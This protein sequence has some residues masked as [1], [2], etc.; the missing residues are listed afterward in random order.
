MKP[1]IILDRD[2]VINEDSENYIRCPEEWKAIPGSLEAIAE[3][4]GAGYSIVVATNQ[5]GVAKKVFSME[6][7]E[8]IHQKMQDN[9]AAKGGKI[10]RIFFCPHHP[11]ER[12]GCRKPEPG[13]LLDACTAFDVKPSGAI[14]LG[15]S[16]RDIQAALKA[17]CKAVLVLTG[18]GRKT[19]ADLDA[20]TSA[21]V[22]VFD[23]LARFAS[24][25][26]QQDGRLEVTG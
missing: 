9:V 17:G 21:Q 12:C 22:V 26:L 15:D 10:S 8:A 4:S 20:Q 2:G 25:L 24:T 19:L 16:L 18:N 6:V 14:F 1:L 3:L 5:A 11:D 23:S 7:L 13:M